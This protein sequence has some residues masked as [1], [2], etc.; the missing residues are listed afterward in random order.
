MPEP[1]IIK[2]IDKFLIKV[3]NPSKFYLVEEVEK[4]NLVNTKPPVSKETMSYLTEFKERITGLGYV[5]LLGNG[6]FGFTNKGF[7]ARDK[8]GHHAYLRSIKPK[9]TKY[10]KVSLSVA[11]LAFIVALFTLLKDLKNNSDISKIENRI[12]GIEQKIQE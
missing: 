7:E 5:E 8:G 10:E 12:K 6:V 3:S 1:E 4:L 11:T 9:M 2:D